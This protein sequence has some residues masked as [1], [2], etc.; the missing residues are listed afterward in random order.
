M[1]NKLCSALLLSLTAAGAFAQDAAP[2]G[3]T[4]GGRVTG[5]VRFGVGYDVPA[6]G[7]TNYGGSASSS[8]GINTQSVRRGSLGAGF[9]VTA[10]GGVVFNRYVGAELGIQVLAAPR[11]YTTSQSSTSGGATNTAEMVVQAKTPVYVIP[12]LVLTTGGD[13]LAGYSRLGVVLPVLDKFRTKNTNT[14]QPSST[15]PVQKFSG[16]VETSNRFSPGLSYAIGLTYPVSKGIR[17]WAEVGGTS[18]SAYAKSAELKS[19]TVNGV[20]QI[21]AL[22][23]RDKQV[24][25]AFDQT[26]TSTSGTPSPSEPQKKLTYASPYSTVGIRLG[27]QLA[28]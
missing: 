1:K 16:E 8:G 11:S 25:Y 9:V 7:T 13:N 17:F 3:T 5:Y 28:F 14:S 19:L 27:I 18:R 23:T 15:Q 4:T 12:A 10:A 20:D 2:A 6:A 21:G 22:S 24:D 26:T